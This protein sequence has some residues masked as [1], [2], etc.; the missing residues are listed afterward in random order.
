M[1][2]KFKPLKDNK[3]GME[4]EITPTLIEIKDKVNEIIE[5]LNLINGK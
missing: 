2:E 5:C 1:I 3:S 4:Y